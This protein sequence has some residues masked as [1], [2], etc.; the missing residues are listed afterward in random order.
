MLKKLSLVFILA[1]IMNWLWEIAHS[2]LYLNYRSKPITAVVLF[3]AAVFDAIIIL[4]LIVLSQ[5]VKMNKPLFVA[6]G[7]LFLAIIIEIWALQTDRWIYRPE[8]PIIPI[9]KIGLTPAIQLAITG[10]CVSK[11]LE[12]ILPS[13]VN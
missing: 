10:F 13:R 12:K 6:L 1:F 7:G 3:R 11:F 2:A 8:M 5:K 4:A 9:I